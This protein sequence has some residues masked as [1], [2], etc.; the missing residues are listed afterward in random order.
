[1][2]TDEGNDSPF[3]EVKE[4]KSLVFQYQCLVRIS[5]EKSL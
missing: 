5:V 1:M 4:R 3:G 2:A